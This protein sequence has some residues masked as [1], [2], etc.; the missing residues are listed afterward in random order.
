MDVKKM[1]SP[2][3]WYVAGGLI[4]VMLA[5]AI[6][7]IVIGLQEQQQQ[8][9]GGGQPTPIPGTPPPVNTTITPVGNGKAFYVSP[10]GSDHNDGTQ[11]HP[12]ATIQKAAEETTPGS[13]VHVLPGTYNDSV[14]VENDGTAKARIVYVSDTR[15]A[16]KIHTTGSDDPW[17]TNADY[18]DIIGFDVSSDN[19]RDGIINNGSYTRTIGNRVHD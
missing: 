2:K 4:L 11:A 10:S 3:M 8:Q 1:R 5:I 13:V 17:K 18:I 15:W 16:A 6:P 19:S 7:L 9:G 12:F 14:D